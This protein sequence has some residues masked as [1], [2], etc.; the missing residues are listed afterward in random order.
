MGD[1][2]DF[3]VICNDKDDIEINQVQNEEMKYILE[4]EEPVESI[5][6]ELIEPDDDFDKLKEFEIIIL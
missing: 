4:V 3:C 5:D 1:I 6:V 2:I